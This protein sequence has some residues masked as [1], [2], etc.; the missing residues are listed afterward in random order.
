M[1]LPNLMQGTEVVD[2]SHDQETTDFHK[3]VSFILDFT[4]CVDQSKVS[5]I[6]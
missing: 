5:S 3:C 2:G 4:P 1:T 6:I